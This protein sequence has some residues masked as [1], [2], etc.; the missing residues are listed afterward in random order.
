[1]VTEEF[2]HSLK[3]WHEAK[4]WYDV[5]WNGYFMGTYAT[6]RMACRQARGLLEKSLEHGMV[7]QEARTGIEL[8]VYRA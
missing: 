5:M 7:E 1:M 4:T 3:V 2:K 6:S 8:K